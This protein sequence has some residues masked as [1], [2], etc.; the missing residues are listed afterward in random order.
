LARESIA[1]REETRQSP[2]KLVWLILIG[3]LI[4]GSGCVVYNSARTPTYPI[5]SYFYLSKAAALAEGHGLRTNWN[6]GV[7]TKYFPGYSIVLAFSFLFTE[8]FIPAQLVS[9]LL[10][11]I[12]IFRIAKELGLEE[13]ERILIV[14]AF[15]AN[16]IVIKWFAL[17]MAEGSALAL[18][19]LSVYLFL[20]FVYRRRYGLLFAACAIG[21]FAAVTRAEALFLLAVFAMIALPERR[22]LSAPRL[23]AGVAVFALAPLLF[24]AQLK[25]GSSGGSAYVGEFWQSFSLVGSLKNLAYNV[26]APFGLMHSFGV[27]RGATNLPDSVGLLPAFILAGALWVFLGQGIFFCALALSLLGKLGPRAKA[28][29]LLFVIYA[30]TH[31]LWHYKYERFMLMA[32]PLAAIVWAAA[33]RAI[34]QS[35]RAQKMGR[36]GFIVIVQL[37]IAASGLYLGAQYTRRHRAALQEDTSWLRF[38]DIASSV[39]VLNEGSGA[40][41]L[42]DLGPHLAYHIDAHTSG[43]PSRIPYRRAYIP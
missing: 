19:L 4:V 1:M 10:C 2:G 32:I 27:A 18:S 35:E 42:T 5:D 31:S 25:F 38:R 21:G 33:V 8:S 37:L 13:I 15:A 7:D 14:T 3:A 28:A 39:N 29:G 12:L 40:P 34:S 41:V 30:V 26:W 24:W 20:Q 11:A 23:L 43:A 6:D 16:P 36:Y 17:P 22:D 9:Y